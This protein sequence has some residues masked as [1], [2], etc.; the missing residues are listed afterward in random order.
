[1]VSNDDVADI[2]QI[3]CACILALLGRKG[4]RQRQKP[5]AALE[6]YISMFDIKRIRTTRACCPRQ[7]GFLPSAAQ[8]VSRP[9][10]RAG[11]SRTSGAVGDLDAPDDHGSF[12]NETAVADART[13]AMSSSNQ[14]RHTSGP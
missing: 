1:L 4:N 13:L 7:A 8:F 12:C 5:S 3:A 6:H 11:C 2:L 9:Q 14:G 10:R